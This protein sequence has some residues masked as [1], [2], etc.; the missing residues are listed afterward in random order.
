M[1][2]SESVIADV[3]FVVEGTA[4]FSPYFDGMKSQYFLPTLQHFTGAAP[5]DRDVGFDNNYNCC[6][7]AVAYYTAERSPD[8]NS[9]CYGPT[10]SSHKLLQLMD[11]IPY[12]PVPC[13]LPL[14][15]K[16]SVSS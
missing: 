9:S 11:K 1:V 10:S 14:I 4:N 12:V 6:L 16:I 8:L 5:D 2:V 3:V 13:V 7:F 15:I